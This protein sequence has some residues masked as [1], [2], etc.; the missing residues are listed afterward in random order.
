MLEEVVVIV[1][2]LLLSMSMGI[3]S[4]MA[5]AMAGVYASEQTCR[6]SRLWCGTIFVPYQQ[7]KAS[8]ASIQDCIRMFSKFIYVGR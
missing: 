1:C 8:H 7:A 3:A 6:T 2:T 4:G 5:V